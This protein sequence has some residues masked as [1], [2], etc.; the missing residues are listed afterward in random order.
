MMSHDQNKVTTAKFQG[1]VDCCFV[2]SLYG[3]AG[4]SGAGIQP[5]EG[6]VP[7]LTTV[8]YL[9]QVRSEQR[10]RERERERQ[11]TASSLG[12]AVVEGVGVSSSVATLG[13]VRANLHAKKGPKTVV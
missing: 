4:D 8:L 12:A 6:R 1:R 3:C 7:S 10:E 11:C 9:V 13:A 5:A 2:F